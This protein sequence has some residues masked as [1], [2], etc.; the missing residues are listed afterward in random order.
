MML[1]ICGVF[2]FELNKERHTGNFRDPMGDIP[3]TNS[4][5]RKVGLLEQ[6][7]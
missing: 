5:T 1:S 3:M 4:K 2:L 6:K 7:L